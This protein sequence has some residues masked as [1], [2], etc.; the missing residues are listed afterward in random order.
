[1]LLAAKAGAPWACTRLYEEYAGRVAGY[2]RRQGA[3]EPDD[4]TSETFLDV[5]RN[6]PSFQGDEDDFRSWLFTIAHRRLIDEQRRLGR[7]PAEAPIDEAPEPVAPPPSPD[8]GSDWLSVGRHLVGLTD[9]QRDVV[10][11]RVIAGLSAKETGDVVDKSPEAVRQLQ[12]RGLRAL[13]RQ[14][15]ADGSDLLER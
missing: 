4:V 11:L 1:M 14:L 3:R 7:R 5:F 8:D 2:L 10:L 12:R 13:E 6:L 9:E 15:H